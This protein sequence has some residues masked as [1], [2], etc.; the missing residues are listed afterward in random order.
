[1]HPAS[2]MLSLKTAYGYFLI[3]YAVPIQ[4]SLNIVLKSLTGQFSVIGVTYIRL[5]FALKRDER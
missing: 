3:D 2:R 5:L 4:A 1:L